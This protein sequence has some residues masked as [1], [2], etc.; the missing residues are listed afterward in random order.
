MYLCFTPCSVLPS[1][2]VFYTG[3]ITPAL[4]GQQTSAEYFDNLL[5]VICQNGADRPGATF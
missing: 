2:T 3:V 5:L 1:P 4:M